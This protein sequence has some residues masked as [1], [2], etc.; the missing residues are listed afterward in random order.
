MLL[1]NISP[2]LSTYQ[3]HFLKLFH[4][5]LSV[6]SFVHLHGQGQGQSGVYPE[7]NGCKVGVYPG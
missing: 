7:N 3:L 4:N 2:M 6:Y 1:T 5:F